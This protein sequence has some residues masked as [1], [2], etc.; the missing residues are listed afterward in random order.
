MSAARTAAIAA[1]KE[2]LHDA[3]GLPNYAWTH[4]HATVLDLVLATL[5][6]DASRNSARALARRETETI[7]VNGRV[8]PIRTVD[9]L[10]VYL[11]REC[12]EPK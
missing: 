9:D 3:S 11:E 8:Y 12:P 2:L 10:R 6:D 4:F 5:P 1:L 7:T